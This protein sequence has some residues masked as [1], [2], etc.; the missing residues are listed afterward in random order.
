MSVRIVEPT[1]PEKPMSKPFKV[2]VERGIP[3]PPPHNVKWPFATMK[4][5]ESFFAPLE[6][7]GSLRGLA[8]STYGKGSIRKFTVRRV[9]GGVRVWRT[10]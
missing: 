1:N 5:G 9:E 6:Y 7:V 3:V 4:V 2:N 10:K 8:S